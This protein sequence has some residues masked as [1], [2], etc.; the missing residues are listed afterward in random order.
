MKKLT[1]KQIVTIAVFA[2]VVIA[3]IIAGITLGT[4]SNHE[5]KKDPDKKVESV[6]KGDKK[7]TEKEDSETEETENADTVVS[8]DVANNE[9]TT[10][11]DSDS[12]IAKNETNNRKNN[13]T[14]S[15]TNKTST[16]KPSQQVTQPTPSHVHNWTEVKETVTVPETGHYETIFEWRTKCCECDTDLTHLTKDEQDAHFYQEPCKGGIQQTWRQEAGQKW[17]VDTPATTEARVVGYK[18]SCGATREK[19]QYAGMYSIKDQASWDR[20]NACKSFFK[21]GL[22]GEGSDLTV[23]ASYGYG[24]SVT[25]CNDSTNGAWMWISLT[26]WKLDDYSYLQD[27]V[28][29]GIIDQEEAKLVEAIYEEIPSIFKGAIERVAPQG[30]TEL[31]NYVEKLVIQANGNPVK[32]DELEG[33]QGIIPENIPGLYVTIEELRGGFAL[34]FWAE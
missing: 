23:W 17:V 8:E 27:S 18:C 21:E 9:E 6:T 25:V 13:T 10:S 16:T 3:L 34:M 14:N 7:E 32:V 4:K 5:N 26:D 33:A 30:G 1:R 24:R 31:Y 15:A 29:E 19:T 28:K 12:T 20:L 11:D 2:V 22:A